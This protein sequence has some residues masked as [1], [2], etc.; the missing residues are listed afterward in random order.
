MSSVTGQERKAVRVLHRGPQL[1]PPWPLLSLHLASTE[2]ILSGKWSWKK[3]ARVEV[4]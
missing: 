3:T 2:Y 4:T 1:M